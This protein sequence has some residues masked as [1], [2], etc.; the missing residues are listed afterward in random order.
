MAHLFRNRPRAT[1]ASAG[2]GE[3]LR[4]AYRVRLV[5]LGWLGSRCRGFVLVAAKE[6][7]RP[8]YDSA[9]LFEA[10][11]VRIHQPDTIGPVA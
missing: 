10:L 11:S 4:W 8:R 3:R 7:G 1:A 5:F 9:D 6:T 2:S